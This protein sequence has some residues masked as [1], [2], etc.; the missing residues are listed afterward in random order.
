MT[1]YLKIDA[2]QEPAAIGL[3]GNERP[4]VSFNIMMD[5]SPSETVEEELTTI[6]SA[7]CTFGTTLFFNDS[8]ETPIIESASDAAYLTIQVEGGGPGRKIQNAAGNSYHMP[9]AQIVAHAYTYRGAR[10]LARA[11]YNVLTQIRN[12]HITPASI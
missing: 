9:G 1:W 12:T 7:V 11:A 3:D 4:Q 10:A 6:L 5:K 8:A 2:T